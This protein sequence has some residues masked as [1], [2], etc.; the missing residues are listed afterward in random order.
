[1]DDEPLPSIVAAIAAGRGERGTQGTSPE[2]WVRR[3]AR[4]LSAAQAGLVRARLGGAVGLSE[5]QTS[6]LLAQGC[7]AVLRG[8][9]P[10][11][12]ADRACAE[13][14][15]LACRHGDADACTRLSGGND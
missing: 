11:P 5:Y 10:S 7:D 14:W 6:K 2:A 3:R 12:E 15:R 4:I 13:R 8:G 9:V 1:M